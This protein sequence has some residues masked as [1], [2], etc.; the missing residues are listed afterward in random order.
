MEWNNIN[1]LCDVIRKTSLD[2]HQYLRS[3]HLE[4]IYENALANRLRKSG[5]D[6]K[7][8]HPLM[9]YD[10]DGSELGEY[11]ADLLIE[12]QLIVELK[13]CRAVTSEHVAQILG[14]LRSSGIENGLLI[15]FGASKLFIKK[16]ILDRNPNLHGNAIKNTI[17]GLCA[18]CASLWPFIR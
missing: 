2:I 12:D 11:F 3:G 14:Y 6:E 8:Q 13:A 9:V 16:Y 18:F 4:K 15:N 5:L 7:Q 10:E 17:L 1:E